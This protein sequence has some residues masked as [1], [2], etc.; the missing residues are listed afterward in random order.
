MSFKSNER[1]H[2]A[3]L[4]FGVI[5]GLCLAYCWPHEELS[6]SA[7][8][9]DAKFAICTVD[10]GPGSPDAVFVLDFTTGRLQGGLLN[11]QAQAFTNFWFANV[12][13]DFKVGKNGKYTMI[14]GSG[15]LNAPAGAGGGGAAIATGVIYIAE[16]TSGMVGCYRFSYANAQN[17]LPPAPLQPVDVFPFRDGK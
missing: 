2:L 17:P 5:G 14:P 10:V 7:T 8:D 11:P 1:H 4:F 15:F 13:Q 12:A 3:W 9:R 6:A 16:V